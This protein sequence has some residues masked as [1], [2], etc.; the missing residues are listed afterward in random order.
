MI[1]FKL[2]ISTYVAI[3]CTDGKKILGV[4][5]LPWGSHYI[6]GTKLLKGLAEAGHEVTMITPFPMKDVPKN[7]NWTEVVLDGI[8]DQ[9]KGNGLRFHIPKCLLMRF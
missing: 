1:L 6:L 2:L 8:D 3:T 4:Y 7:W 5:P 9:F